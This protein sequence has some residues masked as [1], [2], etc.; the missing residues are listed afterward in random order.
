MLYL[1]KVSF[2]GHARHLYSNSEI[3]DGGFASIHA[4]SFPGQQDPAK[5]P[6]QM[7][8][9][10]MAQCS[11]MLGLAAHSQLRLIFIWALWG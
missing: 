1:Q 9:K 7:V 10:R 6:E 11:T 4:N 5:Q 2:P 3:W 8:A